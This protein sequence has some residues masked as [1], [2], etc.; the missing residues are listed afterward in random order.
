MKILSTC[1][2]V[3]AGVINFLPVAGVLSPLRMQALYGVAIEGPNLEILMRHRAVLLG[4][5][6][7]LMLFSAFHLPLRP[8]GYAVGFINMLSFAL[9]VWV[10]GDANPELRRVAVIDLVASFLLLGA[11][12][13]DHFGGGARAGA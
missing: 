6:G 4:I 11:L 5:V 9:V 13:I 3:I 12:L 2:I 10:V 7:A 8:V 1:L